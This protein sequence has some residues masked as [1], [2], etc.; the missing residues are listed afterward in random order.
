MLIDEAESNDSTDHTRGIVGGQSSA[1]AH[2]VITRWADPD[3]ASIVGSLQTSIL[4]KSRMSQIS[5]SKHDQHHS[6]VD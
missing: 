2:P 4:Q 1:M 5:R 6:A 3:V